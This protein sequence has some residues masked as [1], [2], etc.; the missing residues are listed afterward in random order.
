ME[1]N[2][3]KAIE[4][5]LIA[6]IVLNG[7]KLKDFPLWSGTSQGWTVSLLLFNIVLEVHLY[8]KGHFSQIQHCGLIVDSF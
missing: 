4:K 8:F 3:L 2:I 7:E 6:S 1:H 5:R